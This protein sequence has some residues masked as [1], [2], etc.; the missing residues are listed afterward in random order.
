[1]TL[2]DHLRWRGIEQACQKCGGAGSRTYGSTATWRGGIGG[3]AMTDD[4]CDKCWGSGDANKSW[5]NLRTLDADLDKKV[6]ARAV[7]FF[8][9]FTSIE[10]YRPAMEALILELRKLARGR[11]ERPRD[12]HTVTTYLADHLEQAI[13]AEQIRKAHNR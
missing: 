4:V 6:A 13:S 2:E 12:F 3:A 8:T 7:S 5:T 1:M 10:S 11:K 9:G